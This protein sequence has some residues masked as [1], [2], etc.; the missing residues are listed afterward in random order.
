[1]SLLFFASITNICFATVVTNAHGVCGNCG[2]VAFQCR[3]CRHINYD[4]LDAFLCIECGYCASGSFS[5]EL[6]SGVASNAV[7]ITNDK[8]C[9][10]AVKIIGAANS[11]HDDLRN[12]LRERFRGVN[13]RKK[14]SSKK[15][16]IGDVFNP[17]MKRAFLG[18]PPISQREKEEQETS[19]ID[20][21]DKQGSVVKFIARP[22]SSNIGG[23]S[24]VAVDRTRSLLRL[25]RQIRSESGTSSDR[26]RSGDL[27]IRHLG[28]G[29]AID[30]LEEEHDLIGLL[31]SGSG[32]DA[33][34]PLSRVIASVQSRRRAETER[35]GNQ[36]RR[37]QESTGAG[38]RSKKN[39]S[40]KEVL[41]DCQR[42]HMLMREAER[43]GYELRRRIDAWKRLDGGSLAEIGSIT[44]D[45]VTYVSSHC[46]VC[47]TT[48]ALQLLIL[49]LRLFLAR[50]SD[51][52][53]DRDFLTVLLEEIPTAGKAL[54]DCKR[55]VVREIATKS[56]DGA[57]LVLSELRKRLKATNDITS[58]EILGKIME[59]E[60]FS[61]AEE[62]SKLAMEVLAARQG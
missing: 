6:T 21:V 11:I 5:F 55:Q 9:E 44:M 41:A 45:Q 30:H 12:A 62:Y 22:E 27:I 20:H 59:V 14:A 3:K 4:R 37:G 36:S 2:E 56:K 53:V 23:H 61:M 34:E 47:G 10:R 33:S 35:A 46:S 39:E 51:V 19:L 58:A 50:P 29:M 15:D 31:E 52:C 42:L 54:S 40:A 17:E 32:L 26:R 13:E 25:A 60:G 43:E 16:D 18:L 38:L 7:A 24:S 57:K 49:W 1:V 8:D 48:V 28:R